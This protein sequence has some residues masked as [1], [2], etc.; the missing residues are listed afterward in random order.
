MKK[1][2]VITGLLLLPFFVKAQ[3]T[4]STIVPLQPVVTGTSFQ[5][6]YVIEGA[7]T[8]DDFKPSV[9]ENFRIVTGP[10]IYNGTTASITGLKRI[11]NIVYTLEATR[12]G[13]FLIRGAAV[14]IN[15]RN[16]ESNNVFL[17]VISE[18]EAIR[19]ARQKKENSISNYFLRPGEDPYKKI[20]ENLF[21][22]VQ[23]DKKT[24]YAG[25]PVLA[26]FKL[27]SCLESK[28]D[29]VKNPGFYG[30][31]VFDMINLSDKEVLA[32]KINGKIFDVH[33]IR[34]VQLFPLQA[35]VFTIDP[36]EIRNRVE[37]SSTAV[38]RK[39]EQEIVEGMF[40]NREEVEKNDV[41][42]YETEISTESIIINVAPIPA[43]NK[44]V[45][46]SGAIGRFFITASLLKNELA[47]NEEGMLEVTINGT[48]NFIQLTAPSINWP[49]GI[50]AFEPTVKDNF[51]KS[52]SPLTGS[53]IFR[54][55]FVCSVKGLNIIPPIQFNYFD[56]DSNSY[57]TISTSLVKLDVIEEQRVNPVESKSKTSM[58]EVNKTSS[59]IVAGIVIGLVLL[60]LIYWFGKRKEITTEVN[61]VLGARLDADEILQP[62]A[63]LINADDNQFYSCLYQTLWK[64]LAENFKLEG[65][66]MSRN[67]LIYAAEQNGL[68]K[69][70]I[71]KLE[72]VLSECETV[73]FTNAA[74][75]QER[76]LL[77]QSAK[78][79]INAVEKNL[80]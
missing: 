29:I 52:I 30:F 62:A 53:R 49:E 34:K 51:D 23:V 72:L 78:V 28:S 48:G 76:D 80:L 7:E 35:G 1:I 69:E 64:Y 61:N 60:V 79:V 12:P 36:M 42:N 65:S 68:S 31:S 59:R 24:C 67:K 15:N 66:G 13:K 20:K 55:P 74:P 5:V 58:T 19:I 25:E 41:V 50:D 21:L 17:I 2:V 37:F 33:T 4:F 44:P 10:N 73:Q 39:T 3:I 22:K 56:I 14:T 27:Y 45:D 43:K 71:N 46:F 75:L 6:Q 11:R 70:I 63:E 8:F 47:K 77:L 32:E 54:F 57:K 38:S 9:F 16:Y 40:G 18:K 26:T